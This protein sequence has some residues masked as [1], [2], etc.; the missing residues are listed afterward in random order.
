MKLHST[1]SSS[2]A[3]THI[4]A[5]PHTHNTHN[6]HHTHT[7]I[8][9]FPKMIIHCIGVGRSHCVCWSIVCIVNGSLSSVTTRNN[10]IPWFLGI[11][12]ETFIASSLCRQQQQQKQQ[13]WQHRQCNASGVRYSTTKYATYGLKLPEKRYQPASQVLQKT[14][15][16]MVLMKFRERENQLRHFCSDSFAAQ[17]RLWKS[18]THFILR[19][20][21]VVVVLFVAIAAAEIAETS[22]RPSRFESCF[23]HF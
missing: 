23:V 4:H 12:D 1:N 21:C 13:Q 22:L 9:R 15:Q 2:C 14:M 10:I 11:F 17:F 18:N 7:H 8:W 6:T 16:L 19:K 20:H 5:P 3:N